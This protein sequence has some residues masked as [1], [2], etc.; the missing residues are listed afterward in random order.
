MG[1]RCLVLQVQQRVQVPL[2]SA[3]GLFQQ[4]D[5]LVVVAGVRVHTEAYATDHVRGGDAGAVDVYV[6]APGAAAMEAP[7]KPVRTNCWAVAAP[8][9]C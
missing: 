1:I 2:G 7:A 6:T 9:T 8:A 3:V 5:G 4:C